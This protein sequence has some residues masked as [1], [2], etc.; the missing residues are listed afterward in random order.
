MD[1]A[2]VQQFSTPVVKARRK[3]RNELAPVWDT[4]DRRSDGDDEKWFFSVAAFDEWKDTMTLEHAE[5]GAGEGAEGEGMLDS[6]VYDEWG[7]AVGVGDGDL[8]TLAKDWNIKYYKVR[9]GYRTPDTH[10][11]GTMRCSDV[12]CSAVIHSIHALRH[13]S[14]TLIHPPHSVHVTSRPSPL[15]A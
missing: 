14:T 7:E 6:I 13:S 12:W 8:W 10:G 11:T 4:R 3:K 5:Q 2:F 1:S 15:T 9:R